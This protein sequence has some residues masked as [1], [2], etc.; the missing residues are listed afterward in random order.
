[1]DPDR[2]EEI[3]RIDE[4]VFVNAHAESW[5]I[6]GIAERAKLFMNVFTIF[7]GIR[8]VGVNDVTVANSIGFCIFRVPQNHLQNSLKAAHLGVYNFITV[9]SCLLHRMDEH[10]LP[11]SPV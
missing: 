5:Q 7:I 4:T 6:P 10:P 2:I 3:H 1:M 11:E 8:N 9:T